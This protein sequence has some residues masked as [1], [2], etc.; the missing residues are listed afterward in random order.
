M[1]LFSCESSPSFLPLTR[2]TLGF[3][4]VPLGLGDKSAEVSV[5][6]IPIGGLINC[7]GSLGCVEE[8]FCGGLLVVAFDRVLDSGT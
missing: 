5:E 6:E 8:W 1:G 3:L 4:E 7:G 2:S